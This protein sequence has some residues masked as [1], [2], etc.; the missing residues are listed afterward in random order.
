MSNAITG[1]IDGTQTAQ[2]AFATMFKNIGKAFIDMAT[3]MI[4]K[5][6]IMK[7]LGILGGAGGGM[8]GGF[9]GAGGL[10]S[11]GSFG[12]GS[13]GQMFSFAGGGF[14]GDGPRIGGVDGQGGFPALL[15]PGETVVDH[16]QGDS[17]MDAA[18]ARYSP[19]NQQQQAGG[20]DQSSTLDVSYTVSS[21]N[22]VRY[23][24]EDQFQAGM[25]NA[26]KQGAEMGRAMTF[27]T[28]RNAPST[29]RRLGI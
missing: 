9:G 7:V 13:G 26:A 12:F 22:D 15:H 25:R 11:S 4:A 20:S 5:A 14:T 19:G 6:L 1:L 24:T 3:Q 18:M 29:R 21:I 27:N 16:R 2:E 17:G 28:M 10:F 8:G 23:V